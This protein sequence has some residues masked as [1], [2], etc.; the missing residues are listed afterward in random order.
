MNLPPPNW[1]VI[2]AVFFAAVFIGTALAL[3]VW[4]MLDWYEDR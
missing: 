3:L 1:Q 2:F 4:V